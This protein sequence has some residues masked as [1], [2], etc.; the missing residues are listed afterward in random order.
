MKANAKN[1]GALAERKEHENYDLRRYLQEQDELS[2]E[3]VNRLV[4]DITRRVWAC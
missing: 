4:S 3:E 2:E 1:I